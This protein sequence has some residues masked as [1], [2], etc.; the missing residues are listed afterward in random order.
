M[1]YWAAL[2]ELY[3][4]KQRFDKAIATL[5][6]LANTEEADAVSRRGRRHMPEAEREQVSER[7]RRYWEARRNNRAKA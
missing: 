3:V 1:D 7:M 5:E 4:E 2:R 6:A